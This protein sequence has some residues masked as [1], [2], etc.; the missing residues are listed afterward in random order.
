MS[1]NP[2]TKHF[3]GSKG[4]FWFTLSICLL[5]VVL[6][7]MFS[8]EMKVHRL[9]IGES[10]VKIDFDGKNKTTEE[11][12]KTL[13]TS[14][15]GVMSKEKLAEISRKELELKQRELDL[16]LQELNKRLEASQQTATLDDTPQVK[17]VPKINLTGLWTGEDGVQYN[18]TQIGD[19]IT[20]QEMNPML[21]V[22]VVAEGGIVGDQ[23]DLHY[24][25]MLGS[26]GSGSLN[27]ANNGH[28][29]HGVFYDNNFGVETELSLRR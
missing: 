16:K 11:A 19:R 10:T 13:P 8:G 4:F 27:I 23:V 21:G 25:S 1:D 3:F 18:I 14:A 6:Y 17:S 5:L 26:T 28:H 24:T 7:N 2:S 20:F 9:E 12:A 15:G 29:L 22:T